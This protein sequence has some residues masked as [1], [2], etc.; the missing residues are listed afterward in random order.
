MLNASS[1]I[2]RVP[3]DIAA[4]HIE[5]AE[6]AITVIKERIVARTMHEHNG[7][8]GMVGNGLLE[9]SGNFIQCLVPRNAFKAAFATLTHALHREFQTFL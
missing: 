9:A 1:R 8:I 5:E 7:F 4:N 2:V 6:G 3:T